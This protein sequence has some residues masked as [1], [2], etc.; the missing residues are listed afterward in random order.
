MR[1]NLQS[2]WSLATKGTS[3]IKPK[4]RK[5]RPK[6]KPAPTPL[7]DLLSA[8]AGADD[9]I[10][11]ASGS[12]RMQAIGPEARSPARGAGEKTGADRDSLKSPPP[13]DR[14]T[15]GP[16]SASG[17]PAAAPVASHQES[18]RV[19]QSPASSSADSSTPPASDAAPANLAAAADD[20]R[21]KPHPLDAKIAALHA[22][23]ARDQNNHALWNDLGNL[24]MRR[25]RLEQAEEAY[26]A[27]TLL[28]N[29]AAPYFNNLGNA[30]C[31][32]G[33]LKGGIE[34]YRRAVEIDGTEAFEAQANLEIAL[35]ET[36][37]IVERRET[38]ERKMELDL[39]GSEAEIEM[40]NC[41]L[42]ENNHVAAIDR[43][44]AVLHED[45]NNLQAWT[46]LAFVINLL[47]GK[48]I[49]R[50]KAREEMDRG[51]RLFPTHAELHLHQGELFEESG[52]FDA[53]LARYLRAI[54]IDPFYRQAYAMVAGAVR[55]C[56]EDGRDE[57]ERVFHVNEGRLG[58][59]APAKQALLTGLIGWARFKA[60]GRIHAPKALSE[61]LVKLQAALDTPAQRADACRTET[62]LLTAL[63]REDEAFQRLKDLHTQQPNHTVV[64][65]VLGV[66]AL[67][68]GD[69][70]TALQV[71]E[72]LTHLNDQDA[73]PFY[74]LRKAFEDFRGYH[75]AHAAYQRALGFDAEDS[76]AMGRFGFQCIALRRFEQAREL[77]Q[78]ALEID[79][80]CAYGLAI[81]GYLL[82]IG[83]QYEAAE[84]KLS[85]ALQI[86]A[87]IPE[88]HRWLAEV[89][90]AMN[91]LENADGV[92][93]LRQYQKYR[94]NAGLP[95][96]DPPK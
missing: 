54:E 63:G 1:E 67:A 44:H 74:L 34:C 61:A 41:H 43:F 32:R 17:T 73:K 77:A 25:G 56:G 58:E 89:Q 19:N 11:P 59:F 65:H 47:P 3:S 22:E 18:D 33:D 82:K 80:Q 79:P 95:D 71:L 68:R 96:N 49:D 16:A 12:H 38:L 52:M 60:S 13:S 31:D 30:M 8:P 81:E 75:T 9:T 40:G 94:K 62:D 90:M 93:L 76:D 27:A 72:R 70:D 15:Q 35:L 29:T 51:L 7:F 78:K 20:G 21:L 46:N 39:A 42:L 45:E 10:L 53:A 14:P 87:R 6:K 2:V 28:A 26:R 84:D 24:Y 64:L 69:F 92:E 37:L 4:P 85:A 83:N 86:D 5:P 66:Q 57:A 36:R 88:A 50:A 23:L 91:D 55:M 48:M